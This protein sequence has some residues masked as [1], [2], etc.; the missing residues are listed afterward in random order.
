M[1]ITNFVLAIMALFTITV[2]A[3]KGDKCDGACNR[4]GSMICG[5]KKRTDMWVCRNHCWVWQGCD[6]SERCEP[7]PE[8]HCVHR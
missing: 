1:K 3:N 7:K 4:E 2:L 5:T 8:A 6:N